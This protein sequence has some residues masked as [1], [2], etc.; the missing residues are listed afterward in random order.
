MTPMPINPSITAIIIKI[1]SATMLISN[2]F[3]HPQSKKCFTNP[4]IIISIIK[5]TMIPPSKK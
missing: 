3:S 5:D 4:K 2:A 1:I